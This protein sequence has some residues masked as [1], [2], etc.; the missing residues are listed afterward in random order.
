VTES[1]NL[2]KLTWISIEYLN[3]PSEQWCEQCLNFQNSKREQRCENALKIR[4]F[5]VLGREKYFFFTEISL[6]FE[7]TLVNVVRL[8]RESQT[9][10]YYIITTKIFH[11]KRFPLF[12]T[13]EKKRHHRRRETFRV[14]RFFSFFFFFFENNRVSENFRQ[15]RNLSIGRKIILKIILILCF[16]FCGGFSNK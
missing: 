12:T 13:F 1:L 8:S 9:A 6:V 16:F 5:A 15:F 3:Q 14:D 10:I 11:S 4:N 7:R 2:K